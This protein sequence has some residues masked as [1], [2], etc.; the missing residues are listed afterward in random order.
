MLDHREREDVPGFE[1]T[2]RTRSKE[3]M[4]MEIRIAFWQRWVFYRDPGMRACRSHEIPVQ[5]VD[6]SSDEHPMQLFLLASKLSSLFNVFTNR[7]IIRVH[8][9]SIPTFCQH[10]SSTIGLVSVSHPSLTLPPAPSQVALVKCLTHG[11]S[12]V[13]IRKGCKHHCKERGGCLSHGN[14]QKEL[15]IQDSLP[16]SFTPPPIS[17]DTSH[18]IWSATLS[19]VPSPWSPI[20]PPETHPPTTPITTRAPHRAGPIH[21]SH[22][23]PIF[24]E[25]W[26]TEHS[27]RE[28]QRRQNAE[29]LVNLQKTKHT[30]FVYAWIRVRFYDSYQIN[31]S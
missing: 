27:L 18:T 26:A 12:S 25:R 7:C 23:L 15:I 3:Q 1:F 13:R 31:H 10:L 29:K 19:S 30:V 16:A 6:P 28:G 4:R 5:P 11:C 21:A 22:V 9:Q 14:M 24:T 17:E 20:L 2:S 8:W